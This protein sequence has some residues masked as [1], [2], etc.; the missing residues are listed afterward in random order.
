MPE[1]NDRFGN[2]LAAQRR[3]AGLTQEELAASA[4]LSVDSISKLESGKTGASFD[5][6]ARLAKALQIDPASFFTDEIDT[7]ATARPAFRKLAAKLVRLSDE[8]LAWI[9]GVVSAA[10][11]S[12]I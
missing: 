3:H 1:L 6:I 7:G 8:Q 2:L 9:D 10:L 11:Q 12:R 4:E 5:A